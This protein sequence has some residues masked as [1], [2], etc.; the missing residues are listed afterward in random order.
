MTQTAAKLMRAVKR[1]TARPRIVSVEDDEDF[2][3]ILREWLS[4]DFDFIVLAN[5][6]ELLQEV[7][8]LQPDIVMIDIGLP[9]PD[10]L[11]L[12]QRLRRQPGL[13][14]APILIVS[15]RQDDEAYLDSIA[16]G[17]SSF[18]SK[19]VTREELLSRLQELL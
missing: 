4:P 12:C 6:E 19:P 1:Q 15:G 5:G 10:G 18:L 11:R 3:F 8:D 16:V 9:G 17:A 14:R 2:Q 13:S 7:E